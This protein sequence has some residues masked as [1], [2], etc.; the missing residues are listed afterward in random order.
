MFI[1]FPS[2]YK[3]MPQE[4]NTIKVSSLILRRAMREI[5]PEVTDHV[6]EKVMNL[7]VKA[8]EIP[9]I[10]ARANFV[11]EQ[12]RKAKRLE[13]FE[14]IIWVMPYICDIMIINMQRNCLQPRVITPGVIIDW[15]D[16]YIYKIT[17]KDAREYTG[18]IFETRVYDTD[19]EETGTHK[20]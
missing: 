8:L 3:M 9:G 10:F 19:D 7:H 15:D 18:Q 14:L 17:N 1:K 2:P 20:P 6:I 16:D 4:A 5:A 13:E 12:L 11:I